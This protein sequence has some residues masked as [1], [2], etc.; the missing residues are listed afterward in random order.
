MLKYMLF[1]NSKIQMVPADVFTNY[2]SITQLYLNN[3]QIST[4]QPSAFNGLSHLTE[5]HL[6]NN[7]L[8]KVTVGVYNSL[9]KLLILNLAYNYIETIEEYAF[10]GNSELQILFLDNNRITSVFPYTFRDSAL[11]HLDLSYNAIANNA[12]NFDLAVFP[13]SITHLQLSSI[14]V[15]SFK[16]LQDLSQL[17]HLD[18]SNNSL[19]TIELLSSARLSY[20]NL[21]FNSVSSLNSFSFK[22][23]QSLDYLYLQNNL[24]SDIPIGCF[25]NLDSLAVLDISTN[26]IYQLRVGVFEG[27]DLLK[28][29]NISNNKI[30]YIDETVFHPLDHLTELNISNNEILQINTESLLNHLN[31]LRF[32]ALHNNPW[33]CKTLA[34]ILVTLKKLKIV[35][36]KGPEQY[37]THF[38]GIKCETYIYA[39][40]TS[41]SPAQDIP[42]FQ[43]FFQEDFFNT[44]FYKFFQTPFNE[45][46]M[47]MA[48]SVQKEYVGE[49]SQLNNIQLNS[50]VDLQKIFDNYTNFNKEVFSKLLE[51]LNKRENG[52]EIIRETN[53]MLIIIIVLVVIGVITLYILKHFDVFKKSSNRIRTA[54]HT[55]NSAEI[56][57]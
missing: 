18:L 36:Q 51:A 23:M 57:I 42:N 12:S 3:S 7:C 28:S 52:F 40:T 44:N 30:S 33:E 9:S 26:N 35:V 53:I 56:E 27:L 21:S 47:Q 46:L 11:L 17:V 25:K 41:S 29:L 14:G 55:T 31:S 5:L 20:L 1:R 45:T 19:S 38:K 10:L 2:S 54:N 43:N 50:K 6:E 37:N 22:D 24:I 48:K 32:I 15:K 13:K 16:G 49:L 8:A 34:N 4:I 39:P